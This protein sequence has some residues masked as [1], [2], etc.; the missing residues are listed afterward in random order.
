MV[1]QSY[2]VY[3]DA[4]IILAAIP[5]EVISKCFVDAN[6]PKDDFDKFV[7]E[8]RVRITTLV[9]IGLNVLKRT[10]E[11]KEV[12]TKDFEKQCTELYNQMVNEIKIQNFGD[13]SSN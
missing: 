1:E 6:I 2:K 5:E 13:I 3:Y 8:F 7:N 4:A 12:Y 11:N 10:T 9:T